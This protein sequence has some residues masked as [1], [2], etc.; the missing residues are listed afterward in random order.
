M[1]RHKWLV[2]TRNHLANIAC[3]M[4]SAA[5]IEGARMTKAEREFI[6]SKLR[7]LVNYI[8]EKIF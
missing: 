4:D 7:D 3:E 6:Q 1:V 2:S 5:A 8:D